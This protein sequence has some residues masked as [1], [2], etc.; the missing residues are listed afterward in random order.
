MLNGKQTACGT[1]RVSL[2]RRC[3]TGS[4]LGFRILLEEALTHKLQGPGIE[5]PTF[6]PP[7]SP[8][9]QLCMAEMDFLC[10]FIYFHVVFV[11]LP[12]MLGCSVLSV[13]PTL[14]SV[15]SVCLLK[16]WNHK[17]MAN[18]LSVKMHLYCSLCCSI[19]LNCICWQDNWS[20]RIPVAAC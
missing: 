17:E 20:P 14:I 9:S 7:I 15:V 8:Q 12:V 11:C 6:F 19:K 16:E 10:V 18:C 1:F 13:G 2:T 5:P 3:S 4:R